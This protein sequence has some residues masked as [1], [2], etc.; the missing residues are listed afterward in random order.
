LG[1]KKE[2][3]D[4]RGR[5]REVT[6]RVLRP[7]CPSLP[8]DPSFTTDNLAKKKEKEDARGR[9]REVTRR[10]L[11]VYG[12]SGTVLTIIKSER[13]QPHANGIFETQ[14]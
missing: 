1:K 8:T 5:Q 12:R 2:K 14:G 11:G 9:Q 10:V 13:N 3:E 6:R 7:L 4:A